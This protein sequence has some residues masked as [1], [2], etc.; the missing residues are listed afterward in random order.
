MK[1]KIPNCP[2]DEGDKVFLKS[3]IDINPGV[4]VLVGCN[5][6]GKS[7]LLQ[8]LKSEA[9]KQGIPCL[10]YDNLSDGN[11][12]ARSAA[13]FYGDFNL[14]ATLVQSSE[15]EQ[16]SINMGNF[17]RKL[18]KF[19]TDN[20]GKE[21]LFVVLD[22]LD[23]GLSI[24]KIRELKSFFNLVV[25]DMKSGNIE[26]YIIVSANSYEMTV[27]FDCFDVRAGKYVKFEDYDEYAAFVMKSAE[28]KEKRYAKQRKDD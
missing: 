14:L 24:D 21:K 6:A 17:V 12:A 8:I 2:Y 22:A 9:Q 27:G 10:N 3:T 13:G 23:S 18:G 20:K 7:T 1:I 28:D 5:G 11:S 25:N 26:P 19:V 4:T 16:I 15:G